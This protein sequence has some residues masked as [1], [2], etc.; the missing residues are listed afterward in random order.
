M[1]EWR[2]S[3]MGAI[4]FVALLAVGVQSSDSLPYCWH[5]GKNWS[6]VSVPCSPGETIRK[7]ADQPGTTE[8]CPG[9]VFTGRYTNNF[10]CVSSEPIGG[11]NT[12]CVR[13]KNPDG[14]FMKAD[15]LDK[16]ECHL[17]NVGIGLWECQNKGEPTT[18]KEFVGTNVPCRPFVGPPPPPPGG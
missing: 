16:Q 9:F 2:R 14:S 8:G 4:L 13:P 1:K 3:V 18:T 17:V 12:N 11:Q 15:C 7:C 10:N 6:A 5:D